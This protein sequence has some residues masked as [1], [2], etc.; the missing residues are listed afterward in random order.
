MIKGIEVYLVTDGNG[1]EAVEFYKGVLGAELK[2]LTLWGEAIP[3]VPEEHKD[4][5]LN[6]QLVVDGIRLQISD[7]SPE[8]T[9]N[10]GRNVVPTLIVDSAEAA[11]KL[12]DALKEEAQE[13]TLELQET[14]WSPAYANLIDKYGIN[15][16]ISAEV[17]A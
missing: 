10:P 6:A 11:Q 4:L 12:Y 17:E 14:F 16:Q 7:E 9:Y 8:F 1:Q 3:D 13:V 2:S 5:V 15:W